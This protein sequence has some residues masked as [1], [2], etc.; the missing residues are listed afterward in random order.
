MGKYKNN[1]KISVAIFSFNK[2]Q[3]ADIYVFF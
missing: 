1:F 2:A 3:Q